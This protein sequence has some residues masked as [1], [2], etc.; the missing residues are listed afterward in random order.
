MLLLSLFLA[1]DGGDDSS[2]EGPISLTL[3]S[4]QEGDTVCGT[5]LMVV[6]QVDNFTLTN[7][8]IEDAPSNI[9]HLHVYLNGQ[10][11][12]QSDQ[13][14]IPVPDVVDAPYQL[15]VDL[16]LSNHQALNPYVGSVVYITVDN[17]LCME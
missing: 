2:A 6:T 9:G 3:L 13:E 11:V 4:P 12:S 16:A 15:K 8:T 5:P 7:E 1:C 10:E 17:S 14:E